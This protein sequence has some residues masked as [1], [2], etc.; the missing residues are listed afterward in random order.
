MYVR[1]FKVFLTCN[2]SK[3]VPHYT[4]GE[5]KAQESGFYKREPTG[6]GSRVKLAPKF[7]GDLTMCELI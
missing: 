5:I 1:C 7:T 3:D 4:A 6:I 2:I